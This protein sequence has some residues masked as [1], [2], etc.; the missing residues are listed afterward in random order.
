MLAIQCAAL[1]MDSNSNLIE[2]RSGL[3]A[4][5]LT[6]TGSG[7][8]QAHLGPVGA[9]RGTRAAEAVCLTNLFRRR[10]NLRQLLQRSLS[11]VGVSLLAIQCAALAMDSSSN[12]IEGRSGL[13]A[14]KLTPTGSAFFQAHLGPVGADRGTRAAKAV[15]LTHRSSQPSAAPTGSGFFQ[16]HLGPVGAHRGYEA[17]DSGGSDT[18]LSLPRVARELRPD[19][20]VVFP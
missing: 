19:G 15:G 18:P 7:F 8:F 1:A 12:L 17:S 14:S 9:D 20:G 5:K 11:A 13:I 16:A 2:G 10:R 3:I 6:P 4:S